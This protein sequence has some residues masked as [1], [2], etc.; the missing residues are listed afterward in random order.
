MEFNNGEVKIQKVKNWFFVWIFFIVMVFIGVWVF[1]YY[2]SYQGLEVILIIVNVE[3]IEGGKIIIKSCS[4]DV[5]VVESVILVDDLMYVE[6]KVWLNFGMEKLL[7]KDI[8]F[9]VVKL[10]IGREGISG[11]GMLL[12]GVYIELQLGVKGSKMDKYDLL[13]LLLLVSFDVKGICVIFDSKKVGQ[14]SLGDLVLFCGYRV[15][16]VEISIFDI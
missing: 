4:V 3:G 2:Y 1:F 11:L 9:W 14:F 12:F 5:G 7:Y 8:V 16:S 13:D 10:Q 6:I 15:G